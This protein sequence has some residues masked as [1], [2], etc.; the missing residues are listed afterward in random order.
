MEEDADSVVSTD[1]NSRRTWSTKVDRVQVS[2]SRS[3]DWAAPV[4]VSTGHGDQLDE[5]RAA[6]LPEPLDK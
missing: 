6:I 2:A 1:W 5:A 4:S 3:S